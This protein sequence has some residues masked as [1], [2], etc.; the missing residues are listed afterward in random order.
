MVDAEADRRG[1]PERK[2]VERMALAPDGEDAECG[3]ERGH[4]QQV[5]PDLAEGGEGRPL[6]DGEL[7]G[8]DQPLDQPREAAEEG[9]EDHPTSSIR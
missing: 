2:H 8:V 5:A 7:V 3:D 4:H 1:P 6:D 9:A